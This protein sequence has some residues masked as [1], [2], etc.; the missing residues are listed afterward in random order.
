MQTVSVIG[1]GIMGSGIAHVAAAGGYRTILF[2][3]S[4]QI[5]DQARKQIRENLEKGVQLSKVTTEQM[6]NTLGRL[7]LTEDLRAA[8]EADFIIEAV[9]E[10]MALKIQT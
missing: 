3:I 5:L 4:N 7:Q 10:N 1:A 6:E 9:P 2:D 8:A